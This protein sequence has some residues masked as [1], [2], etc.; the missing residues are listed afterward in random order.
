[1]LPPIPSWDGLHP[2]IVHFPIAL[3]LVAPILI[4]IGIFMPNRGRGFLTSAFILMLIGTIATWIAVSTGEEAGEI[5]ERM[6][7]VEAVL[8]NH[9]DLAETTRNVFTALTVIF[10]TI[11]LV[12]RFFRKE[13]SQ[14][15]RIFS[16]SGAQK[17]VIPLC[18][19]FLLF[20]SAG[21]ILLVK[22]AHEGGRLVHEFGVRAMM[23]T[24]QNA[25]TQPPV[26]SNGG[27]DD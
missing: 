3:F 13:P 4:L 22:T 21:L 8:E 9:E 23:N 17:I 2:I 18:L 7:N 16:L 19:G 15:H 6:A 25:G 12:P 10:G 11:L 1:M 14:E 20:Y 5:A 24:T 26:G 27:G